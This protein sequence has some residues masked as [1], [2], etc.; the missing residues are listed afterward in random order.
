VIVIVLG[1]HRAGTSMLSSVLHSMGVSMGPEEHLKRSNPISQ[2]LGYWEDRNFVEL[3]QDILTRAGGIW[4]EPPPHAAII[5]AGVGVQDRIVELITERDTHLRWGWKDPR[6]CLT[7]GCYQAALWE[8]DVRYIRIRRERAAIVESLI[9]R[10]EPLGDIPANIP[11]LIAKYDQRVTDFFEHYDPQRLIVGYEAMTDL[12]TAA[13][14]VERLVEFLGI[15]R[16]MIG[17][18]LGRIK[19]RV[20]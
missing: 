11:D 19:V 6:T 7:I 3:N 15:D 9:R 10:G 14:E 4:Y 5:G 12:D 13:G 18:G 17:L 1:M 20:K 16:A 2:P 8:L